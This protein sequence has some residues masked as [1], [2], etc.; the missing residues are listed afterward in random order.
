MRRAKKTKKVAKRKAKR[1][2]I[3]TVPL[4]M[5]RQM[6]ERLERIALDALTDIPTTCQVL[7]AT[8]MHM[9]K[10]AAESA[11][12]D[13][14]SK[15]MELQGLL[16]RCRTIMEANDPVNARDLF[17]EPLTAQPEGATTVP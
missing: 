8:G 14:L 2:D 7:L 4:V 1:R 12:K 5:D 3:K 10:N 11:L 9:G 15:V 17:G 16:G 6:K 13:A